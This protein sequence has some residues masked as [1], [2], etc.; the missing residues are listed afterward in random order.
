MHHPP[1]EKRPPTKYNILKMG[2]EERA[3]TPQKRGSKTK[4]EVLEKGS[5]IKHN[6]GE[7]H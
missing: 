2:L 4:G 3:S 6:A 5:L 7:S 1:H